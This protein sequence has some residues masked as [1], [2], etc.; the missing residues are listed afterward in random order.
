MLSFRGSVRGLCFMHGMS[1]LRGMSLYFSRKKKSEKV[2]NKSTDFQNIPEVLG[3]Q[4][5]LRVTSMV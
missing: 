3:C 5:S 2:K 4:L 1:H